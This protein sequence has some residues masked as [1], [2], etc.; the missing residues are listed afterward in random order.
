MNSDSDLEAFILSLRTEGEEELDRIKSQVEDD[1][2]DMIAL[3][4]EE[5]EQ[6]VRDIVKE[7]TLALYREKT[8]LELK[9]RAEIL[10]AVEKL[11]LDLCH[12]VRSM[13]EKKLDLLISSDLYEKAMDSL[14]KEA[15]SRAGSDVVISVPERD[16]D[17]FSQKG[18]NV[19]EGS[20]N[21]WGGC[22]A[23]DQRGGAIFENTFEGRLGK[24]FPEI[25][26]ELAILF[27]KALEEYEFIS[28]RLRIS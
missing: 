11:Q 24:L 27:N 25:V 17:R 14:V 28:K 4:R 3:R 6:K 16:L 26:R 21:R 5:V 7:Q 20:F 2:A 23:V 22:L 13:I 9:Y 10:N 1:I 8:S 12:K 15:V 19:K 18:Y